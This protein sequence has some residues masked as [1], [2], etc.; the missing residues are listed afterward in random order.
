ML[1]YDQRKSLQGE[2]GDAVTPQ[3]KADFNKKMRRRL[4]SWLAEMPDMIR[5]L[6]GLPPKVIENASLLENLPKVIEFVDTFLEKADPL[7]VAEHE[8]GGK[9]TFGNVFIDCQGHNLGPYIKIIDDKK[10][11]IYSYSMT[12]SPLEIRAC[13]AL[14]KHVESM[15]RYIDPSVVVMAGTGKRKKLDAGEVMREMTRKRDMM[16]VCSVDS[17]IVEGDIPTKPPCKPRAM[18][19][20]KICDF[21]SIEESQ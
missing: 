7:P 19:N 4:K 21:Q 11:L 17:R 1:S 12:A 2:W 10:Y 13:E 16:G 6:N 14:Q 8:S 3:Q 9:R 15:Q 18:I 20:G 5:I